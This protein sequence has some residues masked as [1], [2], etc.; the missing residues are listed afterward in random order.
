MI[1][2]EKEKMEIW[3]SLKDQDPSWEPYEEFTVNTKIRELW[4]ELKESGDDK[5]YVR[6]IIY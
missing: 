3:L 1:D 5:N 2:E 4:R 6:K